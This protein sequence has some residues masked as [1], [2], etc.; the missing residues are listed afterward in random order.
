MNRR[1][2]IATVG[3]IV[4]AMATKRAHAH[5]RRAFERARVSLV[6]AVETAERTVG[7][8]ARAVEAEFEGRGDRPGRWDVKI[9]TPDRLLEVSVDAE[10][11]Q[12]LRTENE[13]LERFLRRLTHS[14]LEVTPIS[15]G[16]AVAAAERHIVGARATE[17]EVR[18]R[19]DRTFWEVELLAGER[20]H[21][22]RV[23]ATDGTIV[24]ARED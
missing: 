17:A 7:S 23:S 12:V 14:E 24:M 3:F 4:V 20:R 6:Q 11:G 2:T 1:T 10:G 9:L 8:G 13:R 19:D 22:V 16:Q 21:K 18:R 5:D 15:I